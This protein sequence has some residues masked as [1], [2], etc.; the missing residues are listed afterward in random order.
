MWDIVREIDG[1]TLDWIQINLLH[2]KEK[3]DVTVQGSPESFVPR[4][5]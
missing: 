4:W 5:L 3:Q 1:V 2:D